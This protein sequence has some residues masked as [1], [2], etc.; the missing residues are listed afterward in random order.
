M[1]SDTFFN[2]FS[3]ESLDNSFDVF[4][5]DL[6]PSVSAWDLGPTH[7]VLNGAFALQGHLSE[8]KR[9]EDESE[10]IKAIAFPILAGMGVAAVASTLQGRL[11][12]AAPDFAL[13]ATYYALYRL[14]IHHEK[15]EPQAQWY[16]VGLM[17]DSFA[18]GV[19]ISIKKCARYALITFR[20][21]KFLSHIYCG[22]ELSKSLAT[23]GVV[24][25]ADKYDIGSSEKMVRNLTILHIMSVAFL[26]P[27][28]KLTGV[29]L[30]L[31]PYGMTRTF[32]VTTAMLR[33]CGG[34]KS[35]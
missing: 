29:K 17:G 19:L 32:V 8:W 22:Y 33:L 1:I 26:F 23:V 18:I 24:L 35:P 28:E 7:L 3:F 21:A 5:S 12:D 2:F 20:D 27:T 9:P 30:Q 15:H 10:L 4:E 31:D 34:V 25:L 16:N 11:I 13:N 14:F 6:N